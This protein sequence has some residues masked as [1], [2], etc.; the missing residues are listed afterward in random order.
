MLT[1]NAAA[2][3]S[4]DAHRYQR[5]IDCQQPQQWH[6]VETTAAYPEECANGSRSSSHWGSPEQRTQRVNRN[7]SDQHAHTT[8]VNR[9]ARPNIVSVTAASSGTGAAQG[10]RALSHQ[11]R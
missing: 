7:K 6:R 9:G 4:R 11:F 1:A 2:S 10:S 3:E 5:S 8:G